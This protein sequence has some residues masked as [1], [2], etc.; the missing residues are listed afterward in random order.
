LKLSFRNKKLP[1]CW[2]KYSKVFAP[3]DYVW[4]HDLTVLCDFT[5]RLSAGNFWYDLHNKLVYKNGK[6]NMP[7]KVFL[8]STMPQNITLDEVDALDDVNGSSPYL[9]DVFPFDA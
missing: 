4:N 8:F 1:K 3:V 9:N 5:S 6:N 2:G 7:S